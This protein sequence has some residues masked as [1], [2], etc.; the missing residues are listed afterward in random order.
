M[1]FR[2]LFEPQTSTWSY[3]LADEQTKDAVIIDPVRETAERDRTLVGELGLTLQFILET[4]VHA[5]HV[6][7]AGLLREQLGARTVV[8]KAAGAPVPMGMK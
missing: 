8:S 3:L 1:L 6:T 5:D 4:H 2:Q 7:G